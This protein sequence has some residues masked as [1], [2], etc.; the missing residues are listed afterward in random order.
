MRVI[1]KNGIKVRISEAEANRL[2]TDIMRSDMDIDL[3][4]L[5]RK[6]KLIKVFRADDISAIV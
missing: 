6:G 2:T 1:L 5:M 4:K 3:I